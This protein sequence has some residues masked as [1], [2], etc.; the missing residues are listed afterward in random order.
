MVA[1]LGVT[2]LPLGSSQGPAAGLTLLRCKVQQ[3]PLDAATWP[4]LAPASIVLLG[5][6]SQLGDSFTS[7]TLPGEKGCR[8]P[9]VETAAPQQGLT[10]LVP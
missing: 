3:Q 5:E 7:P 10:L 2:Q 6:P 1:D 4:P 9:G 8:G